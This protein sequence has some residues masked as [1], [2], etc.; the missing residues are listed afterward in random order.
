M[1]ACDR[2]VIVPLPCGCIC[3]FLW[4]PEESDIPAFQRTRL[5]LCREH[6]DASMFEG[7]LLVEQAKNWP[8]VGFL[9]RMANA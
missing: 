7:S 3:A 1:P 6:R 2:D 8:R 5:N 4:E 9:E